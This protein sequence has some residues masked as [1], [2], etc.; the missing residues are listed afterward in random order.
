MNVYGQIGITKKVR[1]SNSTSKQ[2]EEKKNCLKVN[3]LRVSIAVIHSLI[4][5]KQKSLRG[6]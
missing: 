4:T 3:K 2:K 1:T 5:N 6:L